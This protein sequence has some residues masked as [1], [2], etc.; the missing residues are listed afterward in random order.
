M[1]VLRLYIIWHDCILFSKCNEKLHYIGFE[2][3]L[4]FPLRCKCSTFLGAR[5]HRNAMKRKI[6]ICL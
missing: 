5:L 4:T 3:Q 2:L 1:R 6:G